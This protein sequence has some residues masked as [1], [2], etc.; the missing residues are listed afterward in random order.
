MRRTFIGQKASSVFS[1]QFQK[2]PESPCG[3]KKHAAQ[4]CS[5]LEVTVIS[6]SPAVVALFLW[7]LMALRAPPSPLR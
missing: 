1:G 6:S 5:F 2:W 7:W 3:L 4:G